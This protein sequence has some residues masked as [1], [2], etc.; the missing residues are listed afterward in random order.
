MVN[1]VMFFKVYVTRDP[2]RNEMEEEEEVKEFIKM[3]MHCTIGLVDSWSWL[4]SR[5][6]RESV[7]IRLLKGGG[8]QVR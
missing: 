7:D 5:D 4:A 6:E 1:Y 2:Y 8:R 3:S